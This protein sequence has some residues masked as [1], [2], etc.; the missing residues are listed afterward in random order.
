MPLPTT[1]LSRYDNRWY[2]PGGSPLKRLLWYYV[3]A[4]VFLNPLI[5]LYGLKRSLL[6]A[7]GASV[8]PGVIIKPAVNIKYPW[9]LRI[10]AH[11]WI[12]ERVWID[13]LDEVRI[14]AHCCLSQGAML[15][16]GNHDYKRSTFDLITGGIT[17]EDGA[18]VG[19]QAVV[20]P[21]VT[22]GSHAVLAVGSVAVSDLEPYTI[23]QGNPAQPVRQRVIAS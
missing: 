8:G 10:G 12:G 22:C 14:G 17:L 5:P 9:K 11:A 13:N 4:L 18:W 7:F 20:C 21:G 6:R 19:A 16:T 15:L 1:D 23:Y 3:N 2:R